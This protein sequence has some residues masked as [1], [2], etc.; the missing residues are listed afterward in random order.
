MILTILILLPLVGAFVTAFVPG[1]ALAKR[2]GLGFSV[3]TLVVGIAAAT[4]YDV[5]E[6]MH[7]A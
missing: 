7:D 1:G 3:A 6:G 4:Q 2:V 5:G